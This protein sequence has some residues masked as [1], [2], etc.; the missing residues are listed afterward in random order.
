MFSV[1]VNFQ[2]RVSPNVPPL[3]SI[4][5]EDPST[6]YKLNST[7]AD[8]SYILDG[9][10]IANE[11]NQSLQLELELPANFTCTDL[12]NLFKVRITCVKDRSRESNLIYRPY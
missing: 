12:G 8:E 11:Y 4:I 6:C 3:F 5:D 2:L 10:D 1:S 7:Q 9:F